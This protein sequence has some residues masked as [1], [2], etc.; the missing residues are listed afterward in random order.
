[1]GGSRLELLV[2][3]LPATRYTPARV[4]IEQHAY[5]HDGIQGL[6]QASDGQVRSHVCSV[7]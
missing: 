7:W 2:A 1:M 6:E 3:R 5:T 4:T